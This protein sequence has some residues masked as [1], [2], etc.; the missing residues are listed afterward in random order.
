MSSKCTGVIRF[1]CVTGLCCVWHRI[2][3]GLSCQSLRSSLRSKMS[4]CMC[5]R[6]RTYSCN[7]FSCQSLGLVHVII[8]TALKYLLFCFSVCVLHRHCWVCFATERDDHNAEWV[9]PCRCKGC[10]KWIHQSCLQ[11]WLDEKQKGNSEETVNC[12]QCGTEY[13][14]IFPSMGEWAMH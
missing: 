3:W 5:V 12:P 8:K 2:L 7:N 4:V 11:R 13:N 1:F 14:V 10:T 6:A 9:S